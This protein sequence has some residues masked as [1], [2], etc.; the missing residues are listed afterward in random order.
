MLNQ[1]VESSSGN[2]LTA[3]Q[4]LSHNLGYDAFTRGGVD[5]SEITHILPNGNV[6]ATTFIEEADLAY[7][8]IQQKN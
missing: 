3:N 7:L 1:K 4:I 5:T 8:S 2:G 6:G